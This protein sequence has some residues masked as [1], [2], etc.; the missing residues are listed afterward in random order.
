MKAEMERI[1][2]REMRDLYDAKEK[3]T[4]CSRI[5]DGK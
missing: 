1:W 5:L 2:G 3:L 4:L